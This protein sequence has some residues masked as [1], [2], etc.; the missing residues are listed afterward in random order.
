MKIIIITVFL[1]FFSLPV[2]SQSLFEDALAEKNKTDKVSSHNTS[3]TINGF[4]R[5]AYFAGQ[6]PEENGAESKSAYGEFDLKFDVDKKEFG[7]GYA[8][9]RFKKG[10]QY[11]EEIEDL[12]LR[13]AYVDLYT[14][15]FDFRIGEQIIVWGRADGINPTN[16]IT[17]MNMLVKSSDPDDKRE[18]NFIVKTTV[19]LNPLRFEALWVPSY[20]ASVLPAELIEMPEYVELADEGDYPDNTITNSAYAL[21]LN[22]DF[23]V[24]DGS[25]SYFDGHMVTPGLDAALLA[26][27]PS[28]EIEVTLKPC[29]M[30]VTG[31]DFSTTL[32]GLG[33]RG[34]AAYRKPYHN[35]YAEKM[36][37][38]N[39][40]LFYVAGIDRA[41]GDFSI[42]VQYIGRY[43]FDFTE[44]AAPVTPSDQF[45]YE[46]EMK[47][48]MFSGQT[49]K[50]SHGISCL[51]K[52]SLL[53]E[54]LNLELM[55]I[56]Y[57]KTEEY[58]IRPLIRYDVTDALTFSIGG[59][60]FAG[61]DDTLFGTIEKEL[62][63][64]FVELKAS[65]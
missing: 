25:L 50:I 32:L 4:I 15:I 6:N 51:L 36:Y 20:R 46:F 2:F 35:D 37:I 14:G 27:I 53:H 54:T 41:R 30:H 49:Y 21:R 55:G 59:E 11:E 57:F 16:N 29:R 47:N 23:A 34:E 63:A 42:L 22:F 39:P 60:I 5:G 8:E 3:Y 24:L 18:N 64:G 52:Q 13:E 19:N 65:F 40:D 7:K 56:Y 33:L 44:P 38:P 26:L 48:R 12:V 10:M 45:K 1:I 9:I 58:R 62:S 17:P 43:V 31:I 61:P 28:P